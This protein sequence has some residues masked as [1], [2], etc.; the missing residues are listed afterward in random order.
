[1][2]LVSNTGPLP[3]VFGVGRLT[4]FS[5]IH[6]A[7][8]VS[9][10]FA[11]ELL[12]PGRAPPAKPPPPHFLIA[13]WNLVRETPSGSLKPPWPPL[14]G[15]PLP[16]RPLPPEGAEGRLMP[17]FCRHARSEAKRLEDEPACLVV[18]ALFV[19]PEP[20]LDEP[21]QAASV[22]ARMTTAKSAMAARNR[23]RAERLR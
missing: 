2:P 15:P 4:P 21:P 3:F 11:D 7:Y 6:A 22:T 9:A 13:S 20:E 23:R 16:G 5:R 14:G 8:L 1:M 19:A 10:A 18:L 12:K 17:S